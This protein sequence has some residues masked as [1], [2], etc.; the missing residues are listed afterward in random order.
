[1]TSISIFLIR[2]Y[3]RSLSP[4]HGW[5][6]ARYP[7]GYCRFHPTCSMYA[8]EALQRH[9]FFRGTYLAVR[10][11]LRCHPFHEPSID[12]VPKSQQ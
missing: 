2:A 9:G 1:M 5:L 12:P 3:Q 4:D 11:L 10:R 6:R 7:Y 8:I